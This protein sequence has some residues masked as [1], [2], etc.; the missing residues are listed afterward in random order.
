MPE[1]TRGFEGTAGFKAGGLHI[2]ML[3]PGKENRRARVPKRGSTAVWGD[4]GCFRALMGGRR[5][6]GAGE[7]PKGSHWGRGG[8]QDL[9]GS[10]TRR[11]KALAL[12]YLPR[13]VTMTL[14]LPFPGPHWHPEPGQDYKQ[15]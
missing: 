3:A 1:L 5:A 9:A 4:H 15:V 11:L 2:A 6:S 12:I 7:T 8:R 13:S 10:S 14:F